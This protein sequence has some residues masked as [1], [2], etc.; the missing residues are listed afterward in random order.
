MEGCFEQREKGK[1]RIRGKD[2]GRSLKGW[3]REK[4]A[5]FGQLAETQETWAS[6][7]QKNKRDRVEISGERGGH[8]LP[9][10]A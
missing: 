4:G 9:L 1:N 3:E 7:R 6:Q 5:A 8:K 2:R 10:A